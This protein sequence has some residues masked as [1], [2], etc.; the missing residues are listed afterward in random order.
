V[1]RPTLPSY[2]GWSLTGAWVYA[3]D[4]LQ[5]LAEF[6]FIELSEAGVDLWPGHK[7]VYRVVNGVATAGR[8]S[9]AQPVSA[10]GADG[11][12]DSFRNKYSDAFGRD[13]YGAVC[14][15][16]NPLPSPRL[17]VPKYNLP[18]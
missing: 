14:S 5:L 12:F 8:S 18:S 9:R 15:R 6:P 2:F 3:V 11:S 10:S 13:P 17:R 4:M 1:R 16:T 7:P